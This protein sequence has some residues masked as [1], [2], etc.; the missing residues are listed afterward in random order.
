MVQEKINL[1]NVKPEVVGYRGGFM[2]KIISE[3][4][5][6]ILMEPEE[7]KTICRLGQEEEACAFLVCSSNGFECVRMS[8]PTNG[9]IFKRL[10]EGT[11]RAKGKGEWPGCPWYDG[12]GDPN[13]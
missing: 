2:H 8:Y 13:E 11:I 10:E 5:T 12:M 1:T 3:W 6:E 9:P 7:A 4:A